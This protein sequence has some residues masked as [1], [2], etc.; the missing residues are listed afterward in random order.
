MNIQTGVFHHGKLMYATW[1]TSLLSFF[2]LIVLIIV[3]IQDLKSLNTIHTINNY[4]IEY[5]KSGLENSTLGTINNYFDG[6]FNISFVFWL[7]SQ[8]RMEERQTI[9]DILVFNI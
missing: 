1:W 5:P 6:V 3:L 9:C 8:Y 7:N 2:L 4:E